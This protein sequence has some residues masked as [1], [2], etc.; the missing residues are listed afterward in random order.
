M[1]VLL[2]TDSFPP[3]AGG[4]GRSTGALAE[5]LVR[6]GHHVRVAAA[7]TTRRGQKQWKGVDVE[8]I[9]VPPAHLGSAGRRER[10]FASGLKRAVGEEAW[11]IVHAQ[12]WLSAGASHRALPRLPLVVT[13]RDYWPVCIWSTML[14]GEALCPGCSYARRVVCLAR[15]RPLISFAAPLLPPVI[16]REL[17]RRQKT[18]R[19]ARSVIA[20]SRYV[21]HTLPVPD[22]HVIPNVVETVPRSSFGD[23]PEDLPERFVL[24]VGKLETNKAPDKLFAILDHC[25]VELPLVVAGTGKLESSLRAEAKRRDLD[26]R[27]LGWVEEDRVA[28]LL[29]HASAVVF[30]SRWHEPLSRVLLDAIGLGAVVIAEPTGGTEELIVDGVSG[31]LGTS[32]VELGRALG[33]VLEDDALAARL[34]EGA[35]RRAE[36]EFSESRIIPEIV[37]LYE[38]AAD[39]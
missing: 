33:R 34:R 12:H 35:R 6:R 39:S 13:V 30:P 2:T 5:A 27:F 9:L 15:N 3:G 26:V 4:S 38:E 23:P 29:Y 11:D 31:L 32:E 7:R 19:E 1:N 18:L 16:G 25:T 28:T 37:A 14:S 10:A 8:E 21:A 22:V 36:S 17:R 24:F 20:V